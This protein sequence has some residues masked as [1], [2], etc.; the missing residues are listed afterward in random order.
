MGYET[1]WNVERGGRNIVITISK[2]KDIDIILPKAYLK[3][4]NIAMYNNL[5]LNPVIRWRIGM[6]EKIYLT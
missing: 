3:P 1:V 5:F 2:V 6:Q 4:F